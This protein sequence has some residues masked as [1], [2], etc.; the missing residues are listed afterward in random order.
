MF[1]VLCFRLMLVSPVYLKVMS[2][3]AVICLV[4]TYSFYIVFMQFLY[5]LCVK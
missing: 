2:V 4:D 5:V 1:C 3:S